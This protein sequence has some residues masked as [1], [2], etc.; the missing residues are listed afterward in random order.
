MTRRTVADEPKYYDFEIALTV[1]PIWCEGDEDGPRI[2]YRGD[3][4]KVEEE[5]VVGRVR[6]FVFHFDTTPWDPADAFDHISETAVYAQL[7]DEHGDLSAQACKALGTEDSY[8]GSVLVFDRLELL[9]EARGQGLGLKVLERLISKFGL[10]CRIAVMKSFPL[11]L[12]IEGSSKP[13]EFEQRM[14]LD[15]MPGGTDTEVHKRLA[16]Y[17]RRAGFRSV[18]GTDHLMIKMLI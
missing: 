5:D 7:L 6:F 2:D 15:A 10:G 17:Y 18:K 4:R 13:D 9:P 14:A 16:R 1:D 3:I 11:Q 12:E 8:L